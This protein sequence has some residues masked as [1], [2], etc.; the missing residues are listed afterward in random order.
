MNK[1]LRAKIE[2]E[3][4]TV[5]EMSDAVLMAIINLSFSADSSIT[6]IDSD[7]TQDNMED[8]LDFLYESFLVNVS[9]DLIEQV[10]ADFLSMIQDAMNFAEEF[11]NIYSGGWY[12]KDMMVFKDENAAELYVLDRIEN[13][14]YEMPESFDQDWL[15]GFIYISDTDKRLIS[16]DL[17][18]MRV[19]GM[20]DQEILKFVDT[21]DD[22]DDALEKAKEETQEVYSEDIHDELEKDAFG[23]LVDE[24]GLYPR[25]EIFEEGPFQIE[26]SEAAEAALRL[27]GLENFLHGYTITD[28]NN[29]VIVADE[30]GMVF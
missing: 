30:Q 15:A 18:D 20:T 6:G 2:D 9:D 8:F 5:D 28:L 1:E 24:L 7:T 21:D 14:L 13:D 16:N 23:Y 25:D 4:Q 11:E 10:E 3:L 12:G 19:E 27:D 29:G 26:V 22:S 17:A